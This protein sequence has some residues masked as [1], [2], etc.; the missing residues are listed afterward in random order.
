VNVG[1]MEFL[2]YDCLNASKVWCCS[3]LL[4]IF[5]LHLLKKWIRFLPDPE[6]EL[7]YLKLLP[8]DPITNGYSK[9]LRINGGLKAQVY[10]FCTPRLHVL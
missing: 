7:C 5:P 4:N 2:Y 3:I 9:F 10:V 8:P 6:L 1:V